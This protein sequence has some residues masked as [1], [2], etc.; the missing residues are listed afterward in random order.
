MEDI[1]G[2]YNRKVRGLNDRIPPLLGPQQLYGLRIDIESP[3]F[4]A[5][6]N[7]LG[8]LQEECKLM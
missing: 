8:I 6:C 7:N 5:S 2:R 3:K 4:K 1:K